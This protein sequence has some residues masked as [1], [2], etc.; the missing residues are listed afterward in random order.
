MPWRF[1]RLQAN[2]PEFDHAAVA[3]RRKSVFCLRFGAE[4]NRCAHAVAQLQMSGHKVGM[5]VSQ[6]HVLDLQPVL[7]RKL[8]IPFD[9]ALRI[10]D[11][12]CAR[13]LVANKIRGM[14][15]AIQIELLEDHACTALAFDRYFGWG[16]IRRYGR[17]AFHPPGYF[18]LASSSETDGRMITSSPCFQFTGVAT[19]CFAVS[20]IESSTRSTS[21]KLRP[22][23]IG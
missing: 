11:G 2:P 3:K 16:T 20:C 5:Q 15:Q 4:I 7:G 10:D 22:V 17:G 9:V 6:N 21:S 19:L 14:R 23:L 13:F 1:E 12:G 8:E 18:C